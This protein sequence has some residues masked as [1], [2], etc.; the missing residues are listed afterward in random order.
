MTLAVLLKR[1]KER[2]DEAASVLEGVGPGR[3]LFVERPP[4]EGE[5]AADPASLDVA[6]RDEAVCTR[7]RAALRQSASTPALLVYS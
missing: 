5:A 7:A 3:L 1:A 6:R 2:G 4:E